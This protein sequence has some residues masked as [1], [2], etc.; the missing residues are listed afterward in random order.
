MNLEEKKAKYLALCHAM[1]AGVA[2][3]INIDSKDT[4][5][6]HLR[7]GVNAAMCEHGALAGL[8]MSKGI[9]TEDEY[10]DALIETMERE[11]QNYQSMLQEHYGGNTKITLV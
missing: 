6:K 1:Q 7:V 5:P 9:I 3:K 11:V 4:T 8:L 2:M 10:L